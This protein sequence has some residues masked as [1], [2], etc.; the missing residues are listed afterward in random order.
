MFILYSFDDY[1]KIDKRLGRSICPNCGHETEK[2][3]GREKKKLKLY[4]FLPIFS[5]TKGYFLGC[6][7]C[8]KIRTFTKA[9]YKEYSLK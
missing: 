1:M 9:E 8:G 3:L 6:S 4:Y 2:Y 5:C 7:N